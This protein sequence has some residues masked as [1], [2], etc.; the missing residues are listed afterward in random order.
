MS[1]AGHLSELK[2]IEPKENISRS[3]KLYSG[4]EKLKNLQNFAP[5]LDMVIDYGML[6][7]IAKI[8]YYLL[9]L[10][11]SFVHSWGGA[12]ILTTLLTKLIFLYHSQKSIVAM[13][14]MRQLQPQLEKIKEQY[15]NDQTRLYQ[16]MTQLYS[17]NKV[18]PLSGL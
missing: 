10:I 7:P 8:F 14:K 18:T 5:N 15:K 16:E 9:T 1:I 17:S 6:W 2:V 13:D 4:P 11:H 3:L 12:I